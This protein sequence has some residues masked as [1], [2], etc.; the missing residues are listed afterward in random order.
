GDLP[1]LGGTAGLLFALAPAGPACRHLKRPK[2]Q[3]RSVDGPPLELPP[4]PP[5]RCLASHLLWHFSYWSRPSRKECH[6]RRTIVSL[7]SLGFRARAAAAVASQPGPPPAPASA[8][9][10]AAAAP[11]TPPAAPA[12]TVEM[13]FLTRE[14]RCELQ[15]GISR[16]L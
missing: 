7:T 3:H 5:R 4:R 8:A 13:S 2:H 6:M 12:P 15:Q 16:L 9:P 14:G 10:P 1:G 11:A